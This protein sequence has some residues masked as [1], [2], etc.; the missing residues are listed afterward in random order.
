MGVVKKG[1]LKASTYSPCNP[2][3]TWARKRGQVQ[4]CGKGHQTSGYAQGSG[5]RVLGCFRADGFEH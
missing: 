3:S 4:G 5:S 1:L 2:R